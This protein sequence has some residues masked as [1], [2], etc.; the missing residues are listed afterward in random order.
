MRARRCRDRG[1]GHM[2]LKMRWSLCVV[3]ILAGLAAGA[4]AD[5]GND[6][7]KEMQA[8]RSQ[9]TVDSDGTFEDAE[10]G[11]WQGQPFPAAEQR[12]S[13]LFLF[14]NFCNIYR[15]YRY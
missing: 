12:I 14:Y 13:P 2:N 10:A 9:V 4:A 5:V 6:I 8:E 11:E 7:V 15:L 3:V 1:P